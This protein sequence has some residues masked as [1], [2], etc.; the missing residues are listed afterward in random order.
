MSRPVSP[1]SQQ[2]T[3]TVDYSLINLDPLYQLQETVDQQRAAVMSMPPPSYHRNESY[4]ELQSLCRLHSSE[5]TAEPKA[6]LPAPQLPDNPQMTQLLTIVQEC[7]RNQNQQIANQNQQLS[8]QMAN[9]QHGKP[10][11]I[12]LKDLPTFDGTSSSDFVK[13]LEDFERCRILGHWDAQMSFER[14]KMPL[15]G[16]AKSVLESQ[17]GQQCEDLL[18]LKQL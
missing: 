8:Q 9:A 7:V 2:A 11:N 1:S 3:S 10:V 12:G 5:P 18:D 17:E 4:E 16:F 6:P 15:K 14:L 13:F